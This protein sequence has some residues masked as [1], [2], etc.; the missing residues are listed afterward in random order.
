MVADEVG[1]GVAAVIPNR[2]VR[3]RTLTATAVAATLAAGLLVGCSSSSTTASG[4]TDQGTS[5]EHR[6]AAG[7]CRVLVAYDHT[8]A[9]EVNDAS[10]Q[11]HLDTDPD[12]ARQR[13]LDAT[14]AV[15][16][17][18]DFLPERYLALNLPDEGDV[19]QLVRD[20]SDN[21]DA[22][23]QQLDDIE[24]EL[25]DG[26]D[27]EGARE[28]LSAAFIDFEKVQSLAQPHRDDYADAELVRQLD[29]LDDCRHT[30][31]R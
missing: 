29:S 11:I 27:G 1:E 25:T 31:S 12:E 17:A 20:V 14:A 18:T 13:L 10:Q 2:P 22:V 26:L 15:R 24:A 7:V 28:I 16:R 30:V 8:V 9:N 3:R 6:A 19:G 5:V 23:D 4:A 21:A